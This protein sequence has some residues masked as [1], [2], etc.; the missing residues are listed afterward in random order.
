[1]ISRSRHA[2]LNLRWSV[3]VDCRVRLRPA[4][5]S[6]ARRVSLREPPGEFRVEVSARSRGRPRRAA[7]VIVE[8][9][10]GLTG[11]LAAGECGERSVNDRHCRFNTET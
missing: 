10:V 3:K 9:I 7:A 5:R 6:R 4:W 1:M 2:S 8:E 11:R